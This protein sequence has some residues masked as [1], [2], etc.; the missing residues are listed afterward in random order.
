MAGEVPLIVVKSGE[1][2]DS[3]GD[4]FTDMTARKNNKNEKRGI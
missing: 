1:N 2:S 3:D 4:I